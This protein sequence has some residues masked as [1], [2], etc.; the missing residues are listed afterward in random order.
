[1]KIESLKI[2][3]YR[4]L[5]EVDVEFVDFY[6]AISGANNAGK[7]SLLKAIRLF[8]TDDETFDPFAGD[9]P[10]VSHK[11][12]YPSWKTS[13]DEKQ[14]IS[15]EIV[16]FIQKQ[17]DAGLFRFIETFVKSN[18]SAVE[19]LQ[20]VL[21]RSYSAS[22][23]NVALELKVSGKP[24]DDHY[25]VDEIHKKIRLSNAFYFH[26]STQPRHRYYPMRYSLS[27]LLGDFGNEDKEKIKK[28][29]DALFNKIRQAAAKHK[30]EGCPWNPVVFLSSDGEVELAKKEQDPDAKGGERP[31]PPR[32][33]DDS[34]NP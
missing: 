27:T 3:N 22:N 20:I 24:I 33:R 1:M 25:T 31:Q 23:I 12:D 17:A 5:A 28:A 6:T 34:G 19:T 32:I 11:I 30:E 26:N 18:L 8:F 29:K 15:F 21:K 7:T 4:S 2:K 16:L 13:D 14:D 10:E 9:A